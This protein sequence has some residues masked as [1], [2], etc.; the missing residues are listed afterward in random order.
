M[1]RRGEFWRHEM[2][3]FSLCDGDAWLDDSGEL[4]LTFPAG[5]FSPNCSSGEIEICSRK[6]AEVSFLQPG[7]RSSKCCWK[8]YFQCVFLHSKE[9]SIGTL[10]HGRVRRYFFAA[11]IM[12]AYAEGQSESAF[13]P[14]IAILQAPVVVFD[15]SGKRYG[16]L[17]I[18]QLQCWQSAGRNK[19]RGILDEAAVTEQPAPQSMP[20]G[21]HI[22]VSKNPGLFTITRDINLKSRHFVSLIIDSTINETAR[23]NELEISVRR[24]RQM[25]FGPRNRRYGSRLGAGW[26]S[27]DEGA[28]GNHECNMPTIGRDECG[29][30]VAEL[31]MGCSGNILSSICL[32]IFSYGRLAR[33]RMMAMSIVRAEH[34][35]QGRRPSAV[36]A[37]PRQL[38]E[39]A[40]GGRERTNAMTSCHWQIAV[41]KSL[42]RTSGPGKAPT[43]TAVGKASP[44]A[45]RLSSKRD[46]DGE[47][48]TGESV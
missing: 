39:R 3:R 27:L 36:T 8:L 23:N 31:E 24:P 33:S 44:N 2:G 30:Q 29:E 7:W 38:V 1:R 5:I 9:Q 15:K 6:L 32:R 11:E 45:T 43:E 48:R 13:P 10:V 35:E 46:F 28:L 21:R 16:R 25:K 37:P 12:K 22:I 17:L 42:P 19:C 40:F 20:G 4:L 34:F 14:L 41:M 26:A 47:L 18:V